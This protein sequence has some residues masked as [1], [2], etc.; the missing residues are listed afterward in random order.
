MDSEFDI[1]ETVGEGQYG[2]VFKARDKATGMLVALKKVNMTNER[3]GFPITALREIK[4]LKKLRN[5]NIVNLREVIV[6]SKETV[7][8][9]KDG[10][11]PTSKEAREKHP[12]YLVMDYY[13]HDLTGLC[14]SPAGA[15]F[16]LPQIKHYMYQ[17][18]DGLAY[19]HKN[20]VLHRDLKPANLFISNSG[21]LVVGD[22][23]LARVCARAESHYTNKVITLWYRP[24]ELLM[25]ATQYGPAI[26]IWSA[27][28]ILAEMLFKRPILSGREEMDQLG[29]I[30]KLCGTP[31]PAEL[32]EVAHPDYIKKHN[33]S[34]RISRS[35]R[36][37]FRDFD[38]KALDLVDKI[39][40][41]NPKDRPTAKEALMHD[42]FWTPDF[43]G[44]EKFDASRLPKYAE[45]HEYQAR[46]R[47]QEIKQAQQ[48]KRAKSSAAGSQDSRQ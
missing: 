41:L 16:S 11:A 40:R 31:T 35:V 8:G 4:L 25:G 20:N 14:D 46:K 18:F 22:F 21:Q 23:G 13:Q 28:C 15:N 26:D 30:F 9:A 1:L 45:A 2:T 39:L 7:E 47:R 43:A 6:A 5:K 38:P 12:V 42:F 10:K 17:L 37:T 48:A 33:I 34:Q 36:H 29:R 3:E 27:G 32:Q 19:C 44:G 24:P